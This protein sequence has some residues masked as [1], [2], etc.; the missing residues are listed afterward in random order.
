[1]PSCN[2]TCFRSEL[3][4]YDALYELREVSSA[5][6]G[7]CLVIESAVRNADSRNLAAVMAVLKANRAALSTSMG[8]EPTK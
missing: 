3:G 7:L 2:R 5:L 4:E 6:D 1:M 8:K